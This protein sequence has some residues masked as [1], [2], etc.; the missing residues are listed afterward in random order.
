[1]YGK[2]TDEREILISMKSGSKIIP[3]FSMIIVISS[4]IVGF[5]SYPAFLA[6]NIVAFAQ[7]ILS[8]ILKIYLSKKI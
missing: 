3:I 2:E 5:I 1:M 6:L 4:M 7:I 8:K